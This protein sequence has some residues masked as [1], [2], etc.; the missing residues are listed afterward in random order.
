MNHTYTALALCAV[1]AVAGPAAAQRVTGWTLDAATGEPLSDVHVL[2]I[3]M[4][5]R[6]AAETFS[7]DAGVFALEAPASGTWRIRAQMIGYGTVESKPVDVLP[8]GEVAVEV[9]MQV[10]A[11]P[12]EPVV[13]TG[14]MSSMS[15]DLQG[16]YERVR[17][18][19][20]T[21]FGRFVTREDVENS[22]V[23]EPSGLLRMI[24]GVRVTR[25]YRRSRTGNTI[26]MSGGCVPAIFVDGTQINRVGGVA[27]ELDDFVNR[28]NIEGIEVYRGTGQQVDR[29]YDARGCGMILVWTRR[30]TSEGPPFSWA[31]AGAAAATVLGFLL[32]F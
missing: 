15:P 23:A 21:G 8:G 26:T 25:R 9:R 20:S 13:A 17:T 31:K 18:G 32:I 30:G 24:P 28:G 4:E 3:S 22:A 5:D 7:N 10:E 12:V 1:L 11:V 19:R 2:L 27:D 6:V 14:E 29:F 16:F